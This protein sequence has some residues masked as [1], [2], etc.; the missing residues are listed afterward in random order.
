M[1]LINK[2]T[3]V[4]HKLTVIW[5]KIM[6]W[7]ALFYQLYYQDGII[8]LLPFLTEKDLIS[9]LSFWDGC[10]HFFIFFAS[11]DI[12]WEFIMHMSITKLLKDFQAIFKEWVKIELLFRSSITTIILSLNKIQLILNHIILHRKDLHIDQSNLFN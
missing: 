3:A 11:L 7:F 8:Y 4:V 5:Q 10:M 1:N 2:N 6:P 12:S 9:I